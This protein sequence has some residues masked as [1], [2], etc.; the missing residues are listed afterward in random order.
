MKK[1]NVHKKLNREEIT[2][3]VLTKSSGILRAW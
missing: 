1:V 2:F 3:I